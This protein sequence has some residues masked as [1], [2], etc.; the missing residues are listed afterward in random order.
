MM[1]T[2]PL[3]HLRRNVIGYLALVLALGAGGGYAYAASK[4]KTITVC[5][6]KNTGVFHLKNHG[7]CA[8]GQTRVT[9]NQRGP[10]GPAGP[11]GKDAISTWLVSDAS[12]NR[13]AG[14]VNVSHIAVGQYEITGPPPPTPTQLCAVTVTP[15]FFGSQGVTAEVAPGTSGYTVYLGQNGQPI[16]DNFSAILQC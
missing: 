14:T 15:N 2:R 6:D 10:Q 1:L 9:W 7:R 12:G 4:T 8:R 3:H 11:A 16:D 13:L 5:A